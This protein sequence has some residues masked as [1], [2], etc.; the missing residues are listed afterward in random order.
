MTQLWLPM[1]MPREEWPSDWLTCLP[2]RL[3]SA[4]SDRKALEKAYVSM[5]VDET[6]GAEEGR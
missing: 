5:G 1:Y 3:D 2:L 4:H 6:K